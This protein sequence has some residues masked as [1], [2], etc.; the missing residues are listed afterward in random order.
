MA[1][2]SQQEIDDYLKESHVAHLATVRPDGRPHMAPVWFIEEDGRAFVIAPASAVKLRNI[3]RNPQVA[4]SVATDERP[5]KYVVL[6]G[7]GRVTDE[8]LAA[9]VERICV[10]Y[11]GP[12][13]GRAYATELMNQGLFRVVDI[14]VTRVIGWK[15]DE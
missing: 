9:V 1:K 8:D 14:K 13:R 11:D 15:E 10:H 3:R 5:F 12:E 6:E 7:D 4:L 2:L